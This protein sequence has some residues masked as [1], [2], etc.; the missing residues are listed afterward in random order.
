MPDDTVLIGQNFDMP[1]CRW[2]K[3]TT[4]Q[5]ADLSNLHGH[6]FVLTD[7]GFHP[8]E[9]QTGPAPD[10]AQV[11]STFF[12][13]LAHLLETNNL[14]GLIGLQVIDVYPSSM[15]ELVLPQGTIM[16]DVSDL[17]GCVPTRQTGWKF[18]AENGE[19]RVCQANETHGRHANGHDIFNKGAPHP[20]LE[21]FQD[22]K[23]VLQRENILSAA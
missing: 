4:I 13:E 20:M 9:Y 17:N 5:S 7:R 10:L 14:T 12:S 18:A 23:H 6:I 16:L 15:L 3:A 21:T 8:Y 22:V 19:P 1:R 2:A 11:D